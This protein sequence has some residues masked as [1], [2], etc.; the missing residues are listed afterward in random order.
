MTKAYEADPEAFKNESKN[1]YRRVLTLF[2][3]NKNNKFEEEEHVRFFKHMGHMSDAGD[4]ESFRV[5]YN[6]TDSVPLDVVVEAWYQFKTGTKTTAQND[7]ID[8]AIRTAL[9]PVLHN[10]NR[11]DNEVNF[12]S[13]AYIL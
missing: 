12:P 10:E 4:M 13:L 8:K 7:T 3:A 5:A 1:I 6:S 9:H 2:D 11:T